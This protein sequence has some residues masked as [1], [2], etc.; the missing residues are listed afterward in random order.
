M[1]YKY[2]AK[3]ATSRIMKKLGKRLSGKALKASQRNIR[4]AIAASARKRGGT[5]LKN[6]ALKKARKYTL[7]GVS[8]TMKRS[9]VAKR[10]VRRVIK[11]TR[12]RNYAKIRN[13]LDKNVLAGRTLTKAA[14]E[15]KMKNPSFM[16]R[17]IGLDKTYLQKYKVADAAY[18]KSNAVF[19]K[20]AKKVEGYTRQLS[21]I[22]M[23]DRR[24]AD[25]ISSAASKA[26]L[27]QAK[28]IKY[29]QISKNSTGLTKAFSVDMARGEAAS[30]AFWGT[31]GTMLV[32]TSGLKAAGGYHS[33]K[34]KSAKPL[35]GVLKEVDNSHLF[36]NI[37][38][39]KKPK[40]KT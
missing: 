26:K 5:F 24:L 28:A 33:A 6:K 29:A 20:S 22:G 14:T 32:G 1:A 40:K 19:L 23:A 7:K 37:R 30:S 15:A 4:K 34:A 3:F 18:A 11:L 16:S 31:I 17:A 39:G 9:R 12:K 36:F 27:S 2:I 35:T 25:R 21:A 10:S 8:L 13:M 38:Y